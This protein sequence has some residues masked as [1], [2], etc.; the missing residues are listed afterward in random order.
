MKKAWI[1]IIGLSLLVIGDL[2][3]RAFDA[4]DP[5]KEATSDPSV[6]KEIAKKPAKQSH[7]P[8]AQPNAQ[9]LKRA[10]KA[11]SE[12]QNNPKE[13]E[14]STNQVN[15]Q[16]NFSRDACFSFANT[17]KTK[18]FDKVQKEEFRLFL[19]QDS[20]KVRKSLITMLQTVFSCLAIETDDFIFCEKMEAWFSAEN[21]I[22]LDCR[23]IFKLFLPAKAYYVYR[24]DKETFEEHLQ[25]LDDGL[26]RWLLEF[27]EVIQR[28]NE[29]NC[30]R[31]MDTKTELALCRIAAGKVHAPPKD[32]LQRFVFYMYL[33][34]DTKKMEYLERFGDITPPKV[35]T[36]AMLKE[37]NQ[38]KTSFI[39][40]L[41]EY[42]KGI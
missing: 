19:N 25:S 8:K 20:L 24:W 13:T 1:I 12:T 4:N 37:E 40:E 35:M 39:E 23:M 36:K 28:K 2:L 29:D 16:P 17:L 32:D 10:W 42:C 3:L 41:H 21:Y 30:E 14:P 22:P 27:F 38:C 34:L 5:D 9:P 31:L 26:K 7:K 11:E 6:K 18:P 15:M 33:I